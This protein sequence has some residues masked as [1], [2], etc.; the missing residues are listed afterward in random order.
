[1]PEIMPQPGCIMLR[2]LNNP[3]IQRICSLSR[4]GDISI[5]NQDDILGYND[6]IT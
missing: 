3:H 4:K 2:I 1:M 6:V 5:Q